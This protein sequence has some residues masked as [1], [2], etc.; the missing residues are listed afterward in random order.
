MKRKVVNNWKGLGYAAN[1]A[2]DVAAAKPG[3]GGHY[4]GPMAAYLNG[5]LDRRWL[6]DWSHSRHS[7]LSHSANRSVSLRPLADYVLALEPTDGHAPR[8]RQAA[9]GG[10]QAEYR[11]TGHLPV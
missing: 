5:S 3:R 11:A 6:M 2:S 9:A 4:K 1:N 10:R 8:E 7:R